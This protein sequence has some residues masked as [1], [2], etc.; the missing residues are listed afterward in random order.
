MG[1]HRI[2]TKQEILDKSKA[3]F[4]RVGWEDMSISMVAGE[5]GIAAST[6]YLNFENKSNLLLCLARNYWEKCTA[7]DFVR[8]DTDFF[9]GL[10][11][12]FE[13]LYK[14]VREFN[15]NWLGGVRNLP[16]KARVGCSAV[17]DSYMGRLKENIAVALRSNS[18]GIRNNLDVDGDY[19]AGFVF[20]SVYDALKSPEYNFDALELILKRLLLDD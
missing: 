9:E 4:E 15:E 7:W 20:S 8:K 19:L 1:R 3:L 16:S 10:K 5:C 14:Q 2:I 13:R 12:A 18:S 17:M 6:V 11:A